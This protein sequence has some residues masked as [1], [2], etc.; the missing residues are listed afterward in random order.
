MDLGLSRDA[1]DSFMR[2]QRLIQK[3]FNL[4]QQEY[5]FHVVNGNRAVRSV[6]N[7]LMMKVETLLGI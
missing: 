4:M 3:E 7:E 2:Y 1:F 6:A 5:G